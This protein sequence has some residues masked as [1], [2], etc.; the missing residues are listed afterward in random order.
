VTKSA[1]DAFYL[2]YYALIV[3]FAERRIDGGRAEDIAAETFAIAWRRFD[4][5][6]PPGLAWLYQT[7]RNLSGSAYRTRK[8]EQQLTE[9]LYSDS[10]GTGHEPGIDVLD[11]LQQLAPKYREALQLTYWESLTAAEVAVVVGCSEPAAWKRISR[12]KAELR[13]ILALNDRKEARIG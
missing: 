8:K 1:F 3:R 6:S 10:R 13:E 11:A 9:R 5:A 4:E 2:Q 7:A 12:A